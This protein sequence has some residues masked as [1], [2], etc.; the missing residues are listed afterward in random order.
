MNDL[1]TYHAFLS[2]ASADLAFVEQAHRR[3]MDAG[4]SVWFDKARLNPGCD[5][6]KE[7]EAGCEASRV[8]LPVLTPRWKQSE[9]TKFET[10]GAEAVIPLIVESNFNDVMT[11][12]LT[13]FQGQALELSPTDEAAWQRLFVALRQLLAKAAPEK[14][15]RLAD[16]RYAANP[17][18]V[19]REKELN[20]I[21]EGLHQNPTAVLTQGRVRAVTALGGVGKTTL[22]RQYV[23][24]FWRC[25]PQIFW[26]D[27]RLGLETEY[28]RLCDL[29]I[30][31][32]RTS[33]NVPEK[34]R[35]AL[36]ELQNRTERLL[37][38]DNAEDEAGLQAWLPKTGHCRTLITC[39][40]SICAHG[41]TA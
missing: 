2:Y 38:L 15:E 18:F 11:P 37:I 17:Y 9:W 35:L 26:I 12:P 23:E 29:L 8:L 7:I 34:A 31:N 5:W 14:A 6:H 27:C 21:H 28:A 4:F 39:S 32:Q 33:T 40:R 19:G 41:G 13:R 20:Q 1:K 36:R 30:P 22:A 3:L 25:Y 24:K 10:Y 16:L